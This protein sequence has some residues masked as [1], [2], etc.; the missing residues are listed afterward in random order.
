[1]KPLRK[2]TFIPWITVF[3]SVSRHFRVLNLA[4]LFSEGPNGLI[5]PWHDSPLYAD[6]SNKIFNMVVEIPRWSNAKM[7]VKNGL[8]KHDS[9]LFRLQP[10]SR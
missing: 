3:S 6:E 8:V 10:K 4:F 2:A 1:M 9:T 5:S 7:E